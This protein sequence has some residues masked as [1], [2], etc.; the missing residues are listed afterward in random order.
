M[1]EVYAARRHATELPASHRKDRLKP[2]YV[3][4]RNGESAA[5]KRAG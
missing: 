4:E 3:H 5:T 2:A 1:G